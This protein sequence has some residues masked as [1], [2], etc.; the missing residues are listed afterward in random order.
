MFLRI[1]GHRPGLAPEATAL[2]FEVAAGRLDV[3]E[4]AQRLHMLPLT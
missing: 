2:V 1:N 4:I 3:E